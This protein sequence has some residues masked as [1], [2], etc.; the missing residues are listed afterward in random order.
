MVPP[1]PRAARWS[2]REREFPHRAVGGQGMTRTRTTFTID[3]KPPVEA[4]MDLLTDPATTP[5]ALDRQ[6]SHW[7]AD[8]EGPIR[9]D[10]ASFKRVRISR[11]GSA[12]ELPSAPRKK[13]YDFRAQGVRVS[14]EEL[15]GFIEMRSLQPGL[16]MK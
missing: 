5:E 1:V 12:A 11:G 13:D 16:E 4:I 6:L 2:G 8:V 3:G 9:K 14:K 10:L 7:C 15:P